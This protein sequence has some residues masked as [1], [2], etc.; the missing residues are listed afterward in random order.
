[1]SG[2][3]SSSSATATAAIAFSTLCRPGTPQVETAEVGGAEPQAEIAG[4]RA[5]RDVDR[6]DIGLRA[7]A[8]SD[9][10]AADLRQDALHVLVVQ[11]EDR[12]AVERDL[13]DELDKRCRMSSSDG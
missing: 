5:A 6:L 10:A 2:L 11:A 3:T 1:M 13:V 8:V 4:E 7:R 12:R 9:G